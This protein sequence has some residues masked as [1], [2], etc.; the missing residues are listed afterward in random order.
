VLDPDEG[1]IWARVAGDQVVEGGAGGIWEAIEDVY[2]GWHAAREPERSDI[3]LSVEREGAALGVAPTGGLVRRG[4]ADLRAASRDQ[5]L[6]AGS[7]PSADCQPTADRVRRTA[8]PAPTLHLPTRDGSPGP[9][10]RLVTRF[11]VRD[12]LRRHSY[13]AGPSPSGWLAR[14][15]ASGP[16][17]WHPRD[18]WS[19]PHRG[20]RRPSPV[21]A[22]TATSGASSRPR[23][24]VE[25]TADV[26]NRAPATVY[27]AM[28]QGAS[29]AAST[30]PFEICLADLIPQGHRL[31][32]SM[33]H[34]SAEAEDI[35]QE[36]ALKAWRKRARLRAGSDARPWFLAIVANECRS[37]MRSRWAS[38]LRLPL[39]TRVVATAEDEV[40]RGADLR[41]AILQ[42]PHRSRLVVVLFFYLDLPLDEVARIAGLSIPAARGRLYRSIKRLRPRLES[43]EALR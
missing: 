25:T 38:V 27:R 4:W 18:W 21:H 12:H 37:A 39:V 3:G 33:V 19:R 15:P 26:M 22:G 9:T 11:W 7:A 36:A 17:Q 10:L 1:G 31:A 40:L 28:L 32:C 29:G 42:L 2:A 35:V 20:P 24:P 6:G 8:N 5:I 16:A 14:S 30:I 23:R 43:E 13:A 41:R 34:D